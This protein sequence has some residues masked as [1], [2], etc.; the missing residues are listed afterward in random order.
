LPDSHAEPPT[1]AKII[2]VALLVSAPLIIWTAAAIAPEIV[3]ATG[4]GAATQ[5]DKIEEGIAA[6][7][8]AAPGLEAAAPA[9]E[10]AAPALESAAPALESAA[11]A[12]ENAGAAAAR[13]ASGIIDVLRPAGRLIGEAGTS[14]RI[15][16][17]RGGQA[18]AEALFRQLSKGG[19]IVQ[20][21]TYPGTLVRLPGG[22][23]IGLRPVSTSGPSTIDVVLDGL[24]IREIKFLP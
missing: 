11:P 2:V 7:E 3:A 19:E 12:L 24:G 23:Q 1:K 16:L 21:T 18:A 10:S 22:G 5:A 9:L 20:S 14:S 15:R 13:G 6:L 4:A 17:L 8:A